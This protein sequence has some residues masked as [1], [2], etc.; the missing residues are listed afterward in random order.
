MS[1]WLLTELKFL[2]ISAR[3]PEYLLHQALDFERSCGK[4]TGLW[5]TYEAVE[6]FRWTVE[7]LELIYKVNL[8]PL[9]NVEALS[10]LR[11]HK[12]YGILL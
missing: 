8:K 12:S 4:L 5:K 9:L 6:N 11:S 1:N 10:T 2:L 3:C 7:K